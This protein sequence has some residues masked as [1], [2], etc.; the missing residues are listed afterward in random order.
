[1]LGIPLSL[2]PN[3]GWSG[4]RFLATLEVTHLVLGFQILDIE[5][6]R[7]DFGFVTS[8]VV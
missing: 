3:Q 8:P 4:E 1:V 6:E 7:G 2:I 5:V